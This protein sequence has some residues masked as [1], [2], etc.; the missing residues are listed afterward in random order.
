MMQCESHPDEQTDSASQA[1]L[2]EAAQLYLALSRIT[3]VL[4][5]SGELGSLSWG[6]AAALGTL[7]RCGPMRLGDLAAI[8][9]VTAPTMSRMVSGMAKVGFVQRAPD[10]EDGR[11]QLL[12]PTEAGQALVN[13]VTSAR[14][15]RFAAALAELTPDE[16]AAVTS[17]VTKLV[18]LLDAGSRVSRRS[19]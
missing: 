8:E 6:S 7:V 16:R 2:A 12:R 1:G 17:G 19:T 15:Q 10:P 9:H 11:A 14:V 3:R 18:D 13:G 5:R 4:R